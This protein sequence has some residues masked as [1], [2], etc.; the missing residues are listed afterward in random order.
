MKLQ[1]KIPQY[2]KEIIQE[3]RNNKMKEIKS[4]T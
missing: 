3:L 4:K 2:I 1:I